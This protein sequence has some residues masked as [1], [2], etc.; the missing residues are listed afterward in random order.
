MFATREKVLLKAPPEKRVDGPIWSPDLES[1]VIVSC[2]E[3]G[4]NRSFPAG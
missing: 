4:S 2:L 3:D 1:W